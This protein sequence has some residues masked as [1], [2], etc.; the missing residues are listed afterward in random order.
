M[1]HG[2]GGKVNSFYT[3]AVG[4]VGEV[5]PLTAEDARHACSVLRLRLGEA[6]YCVDPEGRRFEAEIA[7]I[8]AAGCTVRLLQPLP[9]NEAPVSIT[10]YQGLPKADKL[11]LIAQKLTEL[12]AAEICPV[13]MSR[14][15]VKLDVRDA[16]KKRERLLKI[17]R[18]AAKQCKRA[19]A[20]EIVAAMD[21]RQALSAMTRH[22]L[23]LV[24]WEEASGLGLRVLH[25]E[26]P[27]VR[28]IGVV[29]GPEGGMSADEVRA[30]T[31]VGARAI[32]LGPRILR[33]ETAAIASCA[34]IMALWGDLG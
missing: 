28:D 13:R 23:L 33:T 20:P 4:G 22:D 29:I 7:E 14:C 6:V 9:D 8:S 30:L 5:C 12:G 21:W 31:D 10:L 16:E 3:S 2:R 19:H 18:E 11:E 25:G 1:R 32:T 15:V 26:M 27:A 17:A 34:A 24:P